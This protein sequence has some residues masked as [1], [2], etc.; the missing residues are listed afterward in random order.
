MK[1]LFLFFIIVLISACTPEANKELQIKTDGIFAPIEIKIGTEQLQ[2]EVDFGEFVL[3]TDPRLIPITLKNNTLF[4]LTNIGIEFVGDSAGY[5]FAKNEAGKSLFPGFEGTCTTT[6]NPG[7]SCTMNLEFLASSAGYYRQKLFFRYNN[8]VEKD[9]RFSYFAILAGNPASLIFVND[10]TNYIFG[11]ESGLSKTPI[12][13]RADANTYKQTLLVK[14]AGELRARRISVGQSETCKARFALTCTDANYPSYR[15]DTAYRIVN[16]CP[17]MLSPNQ[18]CEVDVYYAPPNQDPLIGPGTDVV[19]EIR[20]DNIVRFDYET[21][22]YRTSAALNAY[23]ASVSTTIQAFFDTSIDSIV[24]DES[25][26]VGN[27][28]MRTFRVNNKG[29]RA[30]IMKQLDFKLDPAGTLEAS[31]IGQDGSDYLACKTADLST[32]KTLFE[33]PFFIKDR[34]DCM[35]GPNE[36]VKEVPVDGGCIFDLTFQPST[37]LSNLANFNYDLFSKFDSRWKGLETIV[38]NELH[39][40]A[41]N[42]INAAKVEVI[43]LQHDLASIPKDLGS[44]WNLSTFSLGRLAL[45]SKNFPKPA[46][47]FVTYKNTGGVSAT[48]IS[49]KDG[50]NRINN[51][52]P[53]LQNNSAGVSLGV[54]SPYYYTTA[55]ADDACLDIAPEATCTVRMKFAPIGLANPEKNLKETQNMFD[56]FDADNLSADDVGY[57]A[58]IISY[59]NGANYSDTNL[60][61]TT[62]DVPLQNSEARMKAT[63]VTKGLLANYVTGN[64]P[65]LG[66]TIAGNITTKTFKFQNIGTGEIP[67]LPYTGNKSNDSLKYI[68][69]ANPGLV[70]AQYDCLNI[71]DFD[72][73]STD[74]YAMVNARLQSGLGTLPSE[75]ACALTVQ[76]NISAIDATSNVSASKGGE[77][78]RK[79]SREDQAAGTLWDYKDPNYAKL[80]FFLD[81]YDGDSTDPKRTGKFKDQFGNQF[82]GKILDIGGQLF[83][84][85]RP[86]PVNPSPM[87]SGIIYRP[88]F[89]LPQLNN[90]LGVMVQPTQ[91]IPEFWYHSPFNLFSNDVSFDNTGTVKSLSSSPRALATISGQNLSDYDYVYHAGTFPTGMSHSIGFG[92]AVNGNTAVTFPS[93]GSLAL[94]ALHPNFTMAAIAFPQSVNAT[95]SVI[96]GTSYTTTLPIN[97]TFTPNGNGLFLAEIT[98]SYRNGQFVNQK[99]G[100]QILH[101][102]KILVIAEGLVPAPKLAVNVYDYDVVMASPPTESLNTTPTAVSMGYNHEAPASN[103]LFSMIRLATPGANDFYI[104]K[105]F[106]IRNTG[107]NK[108]Y[109]F[110]LFFKS[111]PTSTSTT[112]LSS[113]PITFTNNCT[114]AQTNTRAGG[115][116]SLGASGDVDSSCSIDIKY[117]PKDPQTDSTTYVTLSYEI[118]PDQ[119]VF[120]TF[121][122]DFKPKAP[123]TVT[124]ANRSPKPIADKDGNT[125]SRSYMLNFDEVELITNPSV[126]S[127][128]KTSGTFQQLLFQNTSPNSRASFLKTYHNYLKSSGLDPNP[129]ITAVPPAGHYESRGSRTFAVIYKTLYNNDPQRPRIIVEATQG[130]LVGDNEVGLSHEKKGFYASTSVANSCLMNFYLYADINYSGRT[131]VPTV[132]EDMTDNYVTLEYYAFER[133]DPPS[134]LTVH[135]EGYVMPNRSDLGSGAAYQNVFGLESKELGFTWTTMSPRNAV[136]NIVGYRVFVSESDALMSNV[137]KSAP[138]T[139]YDIYDLTTLTGMKL[140]LNTALT[141][142]KFYYFKIAAIRTNPSYNYIK[143]NG[144]RLWP[145]LAAGLWL[146]EPVGMGTLKIL[147]PPSNMY[148]DYGLSVA[149]DKSMYQTTYMNQTAAKSA[150]ANRNALILSDKGESKLFS[151]KL[152]TQAV[153][154]NILLD[155]SNSSYTPGNMPHWLDV[156]YVSIDT[157]LGAVPGFDSAQTQQFLSSNTFFYLRKSS[158]FSAPVPK[159]VGS[160]LGTPYKSVTAYVADDVNFAMPRCFVS[161]P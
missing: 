148:W 125:I 57:K 114:T 60:Y 33:F 78:Y 63:L 157:T 111:S 28:A 147:I 117:Q 95:A 10:K 132:K 135:F 35:R 66:Q 98:Y 26:V 151:Y 126:I 62:P 45:Q 39:T 68:A 15:W 102:G 142:G 116:W 70:G 65:S 128:D 11:E 83:V 109:N 69:T 143:P 104:K 76:L 145:G 72:Y 93:A 134:N 86:I 122:L 137:I 34:D 136:G 7:K 74:T 140:Y 107:S 120:Q 9:E 54:N 61:T 8:F 13:E 71:F 155:A 79:F 3:G 90:S 81:Y 88:S 40:I 29:Y 53:L 149:V 96:V 80:A 24:F 48:N 131:I 141:R 152:I 101:T 139:Y 56:V 97:L 23:F 156:N 55:F 22:M 112:T 153:W 58:F 12:I 154:N 91:I 108:L 73:K 16:R 38:S 32:N 158:S 119:Y 121:G 6:L 87:S 129:A 47:L 52:I 14:N 115:L 67:Y 150:C 43:S 25:I 138:A 100:T 21:T 27:R 159:A 37:Q 160:V 113:I 42:S 106:V 30:G 161:V 130:C 2:D 133:A 5:A 19:R 41:S 123:A 36:E 77:L 99:S 50:S 144:S 31:C 89:T 84:P 17:E 4:P 75:A 103:T 59:K 118:A 92:L 51:N 1:T 49:F 82:V 64:N 124:I 110:K 20:Y 146:S 105:R 46:N 94:N 18:T 85:G 127:F 44:T